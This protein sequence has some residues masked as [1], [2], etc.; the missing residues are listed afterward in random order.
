MTD[1]AQAR[2]ANQLLGKAKKKTPAEVVAWL[3]AVQAQDFHAAKWALGLRLQQATDAGIEE[4]Y[5]A[6]RILRVHVMRPTWHFL[7]PRDLRAVQAL[8]ARRAHSG[9]AA[10]YR[11]LELDGRL[12]SRCQR[13]L[14]EA[15]RGGRH[16]T[17]AELGSRLAEKGIQ[18]TGRRLA[19]ILMHAEFE[20]LICSGPRKGRQF[21]YA[22]VEERVP[23]GPRA[24][25]VS[26]EE[27]L[28][29]WTLPLWLYVSVTGV[30][31][32]W[33]LYHL[34]PSV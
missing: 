1:I 30:V 32:Y 24:D 8:T 2:L 18:A 21:T 14:A 11:E 4:A 5:N 16:L 25:S 7:A 9:N 15:L 23:Q 34:Y 3:G 13:V 19:Y 20:A 29:R 26:R 22:L 31:V 17:R 27:A 6:G 28:A 33:L 10:P 12:L